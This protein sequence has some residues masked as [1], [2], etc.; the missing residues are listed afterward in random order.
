MVLVKKLSAKVFSTLLILVLIG[1]GLFISSVKVLKFFSEKENSSL[2][3]MILLK[4]K[5][6][7]DKQALVELG[8]SPPDD[9][10]FFDV[11]DDPEMKKYIG[12]NGSVVAIKEEDYY[13]SNDLTPKVDGSLTRQIIQSASKNVITPE[14]TPLEGQILM[15]ADQL[16]FDLQDFLCQ[17]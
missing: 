5:D 1:T 12:L 9:F 6:M 10:T 13:K 3:K 11:L 16:A 17:E 8:A 7:E 15:L 2:K 4:P 14:T